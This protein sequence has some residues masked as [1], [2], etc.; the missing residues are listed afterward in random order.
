MRE[1]KQ[2][3]VVEIEELEEELDE[4]DELEEDEEEQEPFGVR[5]RAALPRIAIYA[6]YFLPL[7]GLLV[8]L[9]MSFFY[10][11]QA[12]ITG[13]E[14]ELSIARLYVNTFKGVHEYLG[15]K[16]TSGQN[17]YYGLMTVG[18]VIGILC[19]LAALFLK[20]LAAY[21]VVRAFRAGH[22]SEESDKAKLIFKIAFPNRKW[23]FLSDLLILLPVLYPNFCSFLGKSLV[24]AGGV[25][26]VSVILN[27]PL[28]V[29][30]IF[31]LL[32]LVL[33][34]IIPKQER[35]QKMNMFLLHRT[36]EPVEEEET[37]E[38]EEEDV[39]EDNE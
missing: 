13:V 3:P 9:V 37:E 22:E 2:D 14:N 21:S 29:G 8:L 16:T 36:E 12:Y 33:A 25:E 27:R 1:N 17:S 38:S 24:A 28:I 5:V 39:Y 10:N 11:V 26:T 7:I 19:F 18:A 30:A 20:G 6:R 4:D 32:C 31:L 35:R 34:L 23:L 15:G